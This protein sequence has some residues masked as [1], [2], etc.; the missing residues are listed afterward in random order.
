M[1]ILSNDMHYMFITQ[2]YNKKK[3]KLVLSNDI[4]TI[5]LYLV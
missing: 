4:F 2:V 3:K 5:L 1:Y